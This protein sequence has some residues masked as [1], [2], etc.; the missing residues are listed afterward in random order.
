MHDLHV[1]TAVA[2]V[3]EHITSI[4]KHLFI[5]SGDVAVGDAFLQRERVVGATH[6]AND[7]V[8]ASYHLEAVKTDA[9]TNRTK[10]STCTCIIG[11]IMNRYIV[12]AHVTRDVLVHVRT[13]R[14]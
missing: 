11:Y 3:H 13:R 8:I 10:V 9:T 12:S 4:S 7:F 6:V 1:Y 14:V 5:R 2:K